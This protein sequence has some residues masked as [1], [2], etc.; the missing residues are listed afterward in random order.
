MQQSFQD[1]ELTALNGFP[2]YFSTF[3]DSVAPT[4]TLMVD[5]SGNVTTQGQANS[6]SYQYYDSV[7]GC[8]NETVKAAAGVLS[9]VNGGGCG[10]N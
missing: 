4:D 1:G 6:E 8:W 5:A 7:G 3:S 9:S 2:I 10:K